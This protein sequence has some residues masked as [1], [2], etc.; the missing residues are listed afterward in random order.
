MLQEG[1]LFFQRVLLMF[2]SYLI[3]IRLDVGY[4]KLGYCHSS[5]S[6]CQMIIDS[7]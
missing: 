3:F 2:N 6:E 4:L 1:S 5:S 7:I